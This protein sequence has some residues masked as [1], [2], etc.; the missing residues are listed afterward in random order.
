[1]EALL[2]L[3]LRRFL[4]WPA[5]RC[6]C[7]LW[8]WRTCP[9]CHSRGPTLTL[10]LPCGSE[11]DNTF[12]PSK[13]SSPKR[14]TGG[15]HAPLLLATAAE[16]GGARTPDTTF[17]KEGHAPLPGSEIVWRLTSAGSLQAVKRLWSQM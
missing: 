3:V 10:P 11:G 9:Y 13:Q 14:T 5:H 1:M 15:M 4:L 7:V 8:Y 16:P 6:P 2:E 12:I 17:G